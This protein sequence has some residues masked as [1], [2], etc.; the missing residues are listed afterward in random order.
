MIFNKG[1]YDQEFKF[2]DNLGKEQTI[3]IKPLPTEY[4][5]EL[6]KIAGT[7]NNSD[8][9]KY[10][11]LDSDSEDV[12][13]EKQIKANELLITK[14]TEGDLLDSILNLCN[15]TLRKSYPEVDVSLIDEFAG[16]NWNVLLPFI[17]KVNM[18]LQG[19]E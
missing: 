5:K 8:T 13:K 14:L 10:L 19:R 15:I 16:H 4:T 1:M 3:L 2:I 11:V 9:E 6:F 7:I 18:D 12:K 17:L